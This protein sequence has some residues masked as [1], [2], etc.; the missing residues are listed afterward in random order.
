MPGV[1]EFVS[2]VVDSAGVQIPKNFRETTITRDVK[3]LAQ[4]IKSS[5]QSQTFIQGSSPAQ[6]LHSQ[7]PILNDA[8]SY[9]DQVQVRY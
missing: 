5:Q 6:L 4:C 7:Q 1:G 3:T 8:L 2:D 9:L